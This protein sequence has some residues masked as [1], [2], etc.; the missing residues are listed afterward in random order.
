MP[1]KGHGVDRMGEERGGVQRTQRGEKRKTADG[2]RTLL[3]EDDVRGVEPEEVVP[4]E[5][6]LRLAPRRAARHHVPR[7][8]RLARVA[9]HGLRGHLLQ[10]RDALRLVL[11]ERLV[12]GEADVVAAL[13]RGAAEAGALAA[14]HEE[15]ADLAAGDGLEADLAPFG[16]LGGVADDRVRGVLG[17]GLDELLAG[18]GRGL[19]LGGDGALVDAV[20]ALDVEGLELGAQRFLLCRGEC[21]VEGEEVAL[22]CGL[23]ALAEVLDRHGRRGSARIAGLR[24]GVQAR[25]GGEDEGGGGDRDGGGMDVV[26]RGVRSGRR[27]LKAWRTRWRVRA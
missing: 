26:E 24:A 15:H 3:K 4:L 17:E 13:G 12:R 21:V 16:L 25:E 22:A 6:R 11:E 7:D 23:V 5:E 20:D 18:V 2:G 14:G 10:A 19:L 9:A 8:D 27:V 1:A